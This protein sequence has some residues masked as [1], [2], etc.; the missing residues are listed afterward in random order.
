MWQKSM[1]RKMWYVCTGATFFVLTLYFVQFVMFDIPMF[2]KEQDD[3]GSFGSYA[4]GTLGPLFA[5][6][7]YLGIREQISQQRYE[8]TEQQKQKALE[9]HLHRTKETF[10]KL[11]IKSCSSILPLECFCN[12]TLKNVTKYELSRQ[13]SNVDTL[14]IID[15]IIDAGRL[16]QGTEFVYKNYLYLI[17]Q[18]AEHLELDC[19]LNEHKWVATTTWRGFQK[20]ATFVNIVANKALLDVVIPSQEMFS[21]EQKELLIYTSKYDEWSKSWGVLGLGF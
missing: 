4:S 5:F 18:S 21:Q 6:L 11:Y 15:D 14:T 12:L 8:N 20:N 9:D 3:W 13:L 19:P 2:S 7:A 10:E 16:L 17:E 1:M